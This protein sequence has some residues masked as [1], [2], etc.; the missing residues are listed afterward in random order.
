MVLQVA[1]RLGVA[2]SWDGKGLR[3]HET[4]EAYSVRIT[5][6]FRNHDRTDSSCFIVTSPG[7]SGIWRLI[8][9]CF[10]FGGY[11]KNALRIRE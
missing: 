11:L 4:E 9:W 2:L 1:E 5:A 8:F 10:H 6:P 7:A 3:A